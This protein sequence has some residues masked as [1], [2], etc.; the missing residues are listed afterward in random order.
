MKPLSIVEQTGYANLV[1][2]VA[3]EYEGRYLLVQE[4]KEHVHGLWAFPGGKIDVGESLTESAVREILEETGV[5]IRL[6]G[7]LGMVHSL[8]DNKPG[9]TLELEF[10]AKAVEIPEHFPTSE[11]VLTVEWKTL[12]EIQDLLDKG[13]LRNT[14]QAVIL[15][16]IKSINVLPLEAIIE[17][18]ATTPPRETIKFQQTE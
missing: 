15:Q 4:G 3:V 6:T 12:D 2:R 13:Q 17:K 1:S 7:L 14:T 5:L 8:W 18:P 10:S 16:L 9:F 11:E